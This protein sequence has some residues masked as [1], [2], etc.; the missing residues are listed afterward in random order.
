VTADLV[1]EVEDQELSKLRKAMG[2]DAF[3]RWRWDDARSV[4]E[5]VALEDRF[6]EF[7]TLPAYDLL[8]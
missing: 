4:F 8:D 7:L 1:H 3:G 6:A 5:A 2:E